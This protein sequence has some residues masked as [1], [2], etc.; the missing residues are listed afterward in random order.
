MSLP[1]PRVSGLL[2]F[3]LCISAQTP[4]LTSIVPVAECHPFLPKISLVI[5]FFNFSPFSS[6]ALPPVLLTLSCIMNLGL[7]GIVL[8]SRG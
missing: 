2:L 1:C 8:L 7:L 4:P 3:L 5:D 6:P